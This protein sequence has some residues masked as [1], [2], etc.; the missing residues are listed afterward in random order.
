M[1][2]PSK[3]ISIKIN[4]MKTLN[5]SDFLQIIASHMRIIVAAHLKINSI[6]LV[7]SKVQ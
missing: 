3:D 7:L 2:I 5:Q 4:L 1:N 6:I